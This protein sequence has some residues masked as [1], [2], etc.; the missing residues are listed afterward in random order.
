[1]NNVFYG[2]V[3][4]AGLFLIYTASNGIVLNTVPLFYPSLIAEFGWDEAQVTLPI[5]LF[6]LGSAFASPIGGALLDRYSAKT[7]M[8]IGLIAITAALAYIPFVNALWELVAIYLVFAAGLA[9]GG[10]IPSMVLLTRWFVKYRG[11]AVGILLMASN[12]GGAI[13][14]LMIGG[15]LADSGWRA[16]AFLLAGIGGV[17]MLLPV[18]FLI[19]NRPEEMGLAA[20]GAPGTA[21]ND[22]GGAMSALGD[23]PTLGDAVKTPIFYLLCFVTAVMWFCIVGLL[24]HQSI[25]LGQDLGISVGSLALVFSLFFWC[26]LAGNVIFGYLSDHFDK[27]LIML[28]AMTCLT[29]GLVLLRMAE[30]GAMPVIYAFA[31]VSGL[32]YSGSFT[33]IQLSVAEFFSGKSYGKI[34]GVFVFVDTLAGAWGALVLGNMRVAQGSYLPSFNMM[35]GL[36]LAAIVSVLLL[37]RYK[38]KMHAEVA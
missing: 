28:L 24:Q 32:G 5:S 25:Y 14:P 4:L 38:S 10:L 29:L 26:A 8:I 11:I 12:F 35:I 20:D 19:R 1:M 31:V 2:W 30:P 27:S 18:L 23:G 36:C 37:N 3:I 33:M 16:A 7:L 13:F 22:E 15:T 6:F 17:M 34:L 9:I 21:V